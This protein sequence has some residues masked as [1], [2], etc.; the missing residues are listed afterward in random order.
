MAVSKALARSLRWGREEVDELADEFLDHKVF[1][2]VETLGDL[3]RE[4]GVDLLDEEIDLSDTILL[5]LRREAVEHARMVVDTYNR[6]LEGFL[7]RNADLPRAQLL[8]T[9]E[10]WSTARAD[11]RAE[12]LAIQEAYTA[13]ADA[14]MAFWLAQG[15]EPEF[16]FDHSHP[17]EDEPSCEVCA[18]L[19]ATNPHPAARVVAIGS[20]HIGCRQSWKH[21]GD[22][23]L[24]DE[25]VLP[26]AP[27]GIIGSQPLVNRYGNDHVMAAAAIVA[28]QLD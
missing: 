11:A 20:P 7:E 12:T 21:A 5:A 13:H 2:Y 10:A 16:I 23:E 28:G 1:T 4:H 8:D 25:L 27:A 9:Y 14:T 18:A 15:V 6:D 26:E 19:E 24:P 17:G 22:P 3:Y